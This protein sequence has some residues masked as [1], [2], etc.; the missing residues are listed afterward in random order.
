MS[1][2]MPYSACVVESSSV[3]HVIVTDVDEAETSTLLMTGAVLSP[4]PA[5]VVVKLCVDEFPELLAESFETA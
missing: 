4:A 3:V 1:R 2:L 5:A